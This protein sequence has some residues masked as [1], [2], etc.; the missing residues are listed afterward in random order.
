MGRSFERFLRRRSVDNYKGTSGGRS[1]GV[2]KINLG[3][4]VKD[5]ITGF[6]GIVIGR[7]QWL[8][9]CVRYTVQQRELDSNGYPTI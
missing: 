5:K 9:G 1:K 3:A 6:E 8:Y 4:F 7:T 2:F